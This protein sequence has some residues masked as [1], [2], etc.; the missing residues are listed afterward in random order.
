MKV[1]F[2]SATLLNREMC[3][4]CQ[5]EPTLSSYV[6]SER[7]RMLENS[8]WQLQRVCADCCGVPLGETIACDSRDCPVFYARLKAKS[9]LEEAQAKQSLLLHGL[10]W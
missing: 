6:L 5:L 8:H 9:R 4:A 1:T 7:F 10:A 2:L 3:Y